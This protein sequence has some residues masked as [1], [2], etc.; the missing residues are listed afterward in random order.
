M[1]DYRPRVQ[2]GCNEML[3]ILIADDHPAVRRSLRSLVLSHA[4]WDVCGEAYDGIDAVEKAKALRPDVVLLDISM[5][6]MSGIEATPLIHQA[7][8]QSGI[9]IVSQYD[10]PEITRLVAAAG[11]Q[12][13][14]PKSQ[15]W[16]QLLP[17]IESAGRKQRGGSREPQFRDQDASD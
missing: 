2:F 14:V 10:S 6:N 12:G 13:Y 16:N 5:P 11:A 3:R 4:D 8:P 1:G 9:L 17:A 7:V 15:V